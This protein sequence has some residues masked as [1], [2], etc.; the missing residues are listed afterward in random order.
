MHVVVII[1]DYLGIPTEIFD[2]VIENLG[3]CIE[4]MNFGNSLNSN[5]S[6]IE[7]F[8]NFSL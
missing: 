6:D 1:F 5:M 7:D 2:S 3:I 8:S 4:T